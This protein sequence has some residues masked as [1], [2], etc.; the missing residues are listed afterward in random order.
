VADKAL[1][2]AISK[3]PK[4]P[5]QG[6]SH[7]YDDW[8]LLMASLNFTMLPP[9]LETG[10]KKVDIVGA[11][12]ALLTGAAN[13]DRLLVYF[14]GHGTRVADTN[15]PHDGIV[16]YPADGKIPK[17]SDA[18]FDSEFESLVVSSNLRNT[19]AKLT[20][21]LDCC[22]AAGVSSVID[23]IAAVQ[24]GIARGL[25]V[26]TAQA[27]AVDT[28]RFFAVDTSVAAPIPPVTS[29][30]QL[31]EPHFLAAT[32]TKSA[33]YEGDVDGTIRGLFSYALADAVRNAPQQ[34]I[35]HFDAM[36]AAQ[37]FINPR[38]GD[39]DTDQRGP[40]KKGN[41]PA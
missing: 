37:M 36:V 28:A 10:A 1:L 30:S 15:G 17:V 35:R 22:H 39:Q 12:T 7:D 41:F 25:A 16:G 34:Q 2:I 18:L 23:L 13:G 21:V 32:G 38:H 6:P 29:G 9:L 24:R 26:D 8:K 11:I 27:L 4:H 40:R 14:S 33:A 20:I 5:L 31:L 3:Y 19:T